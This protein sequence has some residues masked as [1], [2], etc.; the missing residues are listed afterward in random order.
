MTMKQNSPFEARPEIF[1]EVRG[2][3]DIVERQR[4]APGT[5]TNKV[6]D[7]TVV[8]DG[9][10]GAAA[11]AVLRCS[12]PDAHAC[13]KRHEKGCHFWWSGT[14]GG[15]TAYWYVQQ[16]Q[17]RDEASP[18]QHSKLM[19]KSTYTVR[20]TTRQYDIH[21]DIVHRVH[22]TDPPGLDRQ[23][24]KVRVP[25][26]RDCGSRDDDQDTTNRVR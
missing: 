16:S 26:Q 7:P 23:I 8:I 18:A 22:I 14:G 3:G 10:P 19:Y 17:L 25:V 24:P 21:H 5:C 1:R 15:D 2:I 20:S 4:K 12:D 11:A 6:P 13:G 9:C